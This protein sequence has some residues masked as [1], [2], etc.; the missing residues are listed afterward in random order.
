MRN[1]MQQKNASDIMLG[2]EHWLVYPDE[3]QSIS[4]DAK[5]KILNAASLSSIFT[6][7][8]YRTQNE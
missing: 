5:T 8:R 3:W 6:C 4:E 2:F 7:L 1:I